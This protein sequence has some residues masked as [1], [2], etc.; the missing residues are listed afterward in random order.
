MG[1]DKDN[2]EKA[3]EIVKSFSDWIETHKDEITA[4]QIFYGQP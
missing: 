1:W 4:L 3:N 2:K